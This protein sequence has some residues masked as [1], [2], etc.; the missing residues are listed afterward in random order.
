MSKHYIINENIC[1]TTVE[2]PVHNSIGVSTN[3]QHKRRY[4]KF[5]MR[6]KMV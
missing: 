3:I 5:L 1:V 2:F 6:L 4:I